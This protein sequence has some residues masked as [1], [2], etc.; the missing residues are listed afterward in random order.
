[1]MN[2]L[3][4]ILLS[5]APGFAL[6]R[7]RSRHAAQI[8]VRH[9]EAAASG[10][11]TEGW[12]RRLGD[13]NTVNRPALATLR[14]HAHDLVRNNPW[15]RKGP[16]VIA[17]AVVGWGIVPS[18]T[19]TAGKMNAKRANKIWKEWANTTACDF[20][21]RRDFYGLQKLIMR[22]LPVAGEVLVRRRYRPLSEGLPLPIQLQVL[23]ADHLDTAKEGPVTGGGYVV[24]GKEYSAAGK[25][26]AYWLF[27]SHPGASAWGIT[28]LQSERVP[29]TDVLHIMFEDRPGQVRGVSWFA[30]VIVKLKDHDELED[31]TLLRQKIAACLAA[32][33]TDVN[34]DATALGAAATDSNGKA[35]DML[36][37]GMILN[38]PAGREI[39]FSNPPNVSDTGYSARVLRGIAA[40]LGTTYED[41]TGDYSGYN[42]STARMSRI[43]FYGN[44]NEWR[45]DMLV[46]QF[47]DGAWRWA[48]DAAVMMGLLS[49]APRA[50]HTAPPMPMLEPDKEGLAYQR[51][52]RA[53]ILTP[54]EMV[55]EQGKD[56]ET[57]W[58]EYADNLKRLD[59]LGIILDSDARKTTQSGLAREAAKP[60]S[61]SEDDGDKKDGDAKEGGSAEGEDGG[62]ENEQED[63]NE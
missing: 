9:Y 48:M 41:M 54:D 62:D 14:A 18:A 43:S 53:G 47:C 1:M 4:K 44:V 30:P 21:G 3:D 20:D 22:N 5:V 33:V 56:P 10:R 51:L 23:E 46:P 31:A 27:S 60:A 13:A 28:K 50:T 38:A 63:K 8:F 59:A 25:L 57:H 37:P 19:D 17:N 55:R 26:Q 35:V 6:S 15:A 49:A 36:E 61:G 58:Q 45:W 12:A 29:A 39:T 40:G 24:Q 52:V 11:R 16:R 2:R 42:F 7:M 34:G 32:V